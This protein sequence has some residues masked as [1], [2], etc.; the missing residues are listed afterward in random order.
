MS[1]PISSNL[2]A[3]GFEPFLSPAKVLEQIVGEGNPLSTAT[4][5]ATSCVSVTLF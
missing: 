4:V 3:T 2:K 1:D 5:R